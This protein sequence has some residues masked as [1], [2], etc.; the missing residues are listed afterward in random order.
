MPPS[1]DRTPPMTPQLA[2]RVAIIGSFA[3]VMFAVIFFR[4]WFLQVLSGN[5]YTAQAEAN[6]SRQVAIAAPRGEILD[7][8]GDVL[9]DS[10]PVPSVQIAGP[11]LPVKITATS[12]Y[13]SYDTAGKMTAGG[14]LIDPP[15]KDQAVY[16][17]L[18]TVLRMSNK[19]AACT[20]SLTLG[21]TTRHYH[22]YLNEVA[23]KVAQSLSQAAYTNVTIKSDVTPDIQAYLAE[24]Q[25]KFP[26]VVTQ[27]VYQR[28]YP[29]GTLAAQLFGTVGPLNAT[30]INP[31]TGKGKG[32]YKGIPETDAVGQNGLEAQYNQ[33]LQGTDGHQ[34]IKVNSQG[35]SEGYGKTKSPTPGENLKL[36]INAQLQKVGEAS[37][38]HSIAVT[39]GADGGAFVAMDPQN[40]QIYAMGSNP[41]FNPSLF[42]K[43]L[44]ETRYR[45]LTSVASNYP[46][47]NRAIADALPDGSTF[48]VITAMAAL[49]GGVITPSTIIDDTGKFCF[50]HED[51]T[52]PGACLRNSGGAAYGDVD[53]VQALKVSDDVFFYNLGYDLDIK[54]IATYDHA[55]GGELQKWARALGIGQTTG[56]DLPGESSGTLPTPGYLKLRYK[57][58]I[59]CERAI[60]PYKGK[61]KHPASAGGCGIANPVKADNAW[62]FGDNVN[63]AVGQG[64][65]Q[66]TPL[67]LAVVYAALA[68]DGTIVTPHLGQDI[69]S[70]DGTVIQQIKAEPRRHLDINPVYRDTILEGLRAAASESGGTSADVMGNFPQQVYGKT[71][72]AQQGTAAE[73]ATNTEKD[74]AWYA[75][76]VPASATSKPIVVVVS[77]EQGGFGDVA[78]APVARQILS[79]WFYGKP[80]PFKTGSST[81]Q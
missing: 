52:T 4:L 80:G 63:T 16:R 55:S 34:T 76:F 66:V 42:A 53:L 50:P 41:T 36:S 64:Y 24:R 54:P 6:I 62:T 69:Q 45:K 79:Q 31:K 60:G 17:R 39:S 8:N 44:S 7:S 10:A 25:L 1:D 73:I 27:E 77:V 32:A 22:P 51:P 14:S 33:Y 67:Q 30:E 15:A 38:A 47:E 13:P 18:G 74:Y 29:L 56:V 49:Q 3:L 57:E 70:S 72:T 9:V 81:D 37:L 5:Q 58:E 2:L 61:R 68:N 71:G 43:P 59:E 75:C 11:D 78:A 28:K 35:E 21:D 26:G 40:G 23:C 48:K 65:D 19:R 20:F 46:L 12:I